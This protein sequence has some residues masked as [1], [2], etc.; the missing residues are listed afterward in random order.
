MNPRVKKLIGTILILLWLP[1]Y[2]LLAIGVAAHL[3]PHASWYGALMF[4]AVAGTLWAVPV[5]AL[6]P[7]MYRPA[8][9]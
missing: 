3:L 7:W 6:F 8:G 1:V 2:A 5:G 9:R 4:Y